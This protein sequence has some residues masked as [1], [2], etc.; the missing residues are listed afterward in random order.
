MYLNIYL[1][2]YLQDISQDI[3]PQGPNTPRPG[4]EGYAGEVVSNTLLS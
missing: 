4:T 2:F 3:E 1:V